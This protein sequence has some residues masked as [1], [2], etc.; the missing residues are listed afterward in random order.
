[1]DVKLDAG[2]ERATKTVAS[3]TVDI[4]ERCS[5]AVSSAVTVPPAA[6]GAALPSRW[7][8]EPRRQACRALNEHAVHRAHSIGGARIV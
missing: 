4:D 3:N 6:A 5:R 8:I 2:G 7:L 1:L